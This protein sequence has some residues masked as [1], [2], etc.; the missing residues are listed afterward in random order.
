MSIR[1]KIMQAGEQVLRQQA[2]PLSAEEIRSREIQ[3]L[4][5]MMRETMRDAPGIGLAAPQIG[6]SIQLAVIEDPVH[7]RPDLSNEALTE[8]ERVHVPFHVIIN[9]QIYLEPDQTIE[10]FEGCLSV[11]GFMALVPRARSVKVKCLN[12]KGEPIT[13]NAHGWYARILQH[14]I[15]HLK[16]ILY[17]DRMH[18]R[19]FMTA[20]NMTRY[21]ATKKSSEVRELLSIRNT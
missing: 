6:L 10:F 21:W 15:D 1:L 8:R 3:Q 17:L 5:E 18:S 4:I 12:E 9:P 16:G 2:Q 7:P 19:S 20:E 11:F 14:E 13:I